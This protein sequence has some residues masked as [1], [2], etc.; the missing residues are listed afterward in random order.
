MEQWPT[1]FSDF[2]T[3]IQSSSSSG[4]SAYNPH[5][6]LLFFHLVLEISGE[7]ADQLLKSARQFTTQRH[8]RDAKVRDAVRDR[9]ANKINDAVLTI[10]ADSAE[11]LGGL[12]KDGGHGSTERL[13]EVIDWGIRT[14]ASYVGEPEYF[15]RRARSLFHDSGWIDIN[16]TVTPMTISLLFSLLSDPSLPIRLAT[17]VALLRMVSKGLK[18]PGDKLQLFKVLSLGQV[19]E[20]LEEKTRQ[21]QVTRGDDTDEG[22]ESHRESLG[23][24]LNAYGLELVK[25]TEDVCT[26]GL[27]SAQCLT[28]ISHRTTRR[29]RSKAEQL[30]CYLNSAQ[31]FSNFWLILM[32]TRHPRYSRYSQASSEQ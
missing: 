8:H 6:S 32:T 14:F 30:L 11:K 19:L 3:L 25:L 22:E 16:L 26:S 13:E 15:P 21:Q 5:V 29:K 4:D 20:A 23:R 9:D 10:V 24:L 1:F 2:F 28:R 18:E 27:Q 17:S 12:R 31:Q 7:V